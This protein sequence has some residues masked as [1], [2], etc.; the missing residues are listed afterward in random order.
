MK[1][2]MLD[3]IIYSQAPEKINGGSFRVSKIEFFIP[4]LAPEDPEAEK[5][6]LQA[7]LKYTQGFLASVEKKLANERFVANAPEQVIAIERKKASDAEEKIT[8][9]QKSLSLL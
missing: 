8:M 7:E 5:E 4:T 3:E 2:G 9:L 6:K 1:L